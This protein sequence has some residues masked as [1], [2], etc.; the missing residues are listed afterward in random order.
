MIK[1]EE[2]NITN[3]AVKGNA[4]KRNSSRKITEI[5]SLEGSL[6]VLLKKQKKVKL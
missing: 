3:Y 4:L 6:S 1:I 2:N 5:K